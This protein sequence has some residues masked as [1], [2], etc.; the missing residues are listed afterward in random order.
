MNTR[1]AAQMIATR[2]SVFSL[3]ATFALA[4]QAPTKTAAKPGAITEPPLPVIDYNACPFEGC[5]F[6]KWKVMKDSTVYSTWR[7]GRTEITKLRAGEEVTALT[8]VHITHK[9]DRILMKQAIPDLGLKPGD[10]VLRYMYLGE[11]YA[12]IWFNGA[13]HKSE[14]CSFIAE[15]G[16]R[17]CADCLAVF[18]EEGDKEWWVKVKTPSGKI[19]WVL[20]PQDFDPWTRS[21]DP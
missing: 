1:Y 9:P 17:N 6:G 19:G 20:V 14:D 5:T 10:V 3:L 18:T 7:K 15:K 2:F 8:G 16:A 4:Q 13:W 21:P 11:G 12:N